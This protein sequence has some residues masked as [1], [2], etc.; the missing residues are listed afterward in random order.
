MG[1]NSYIPIKFDYVFF[2]SC[3]FQFTGNMAPKQTCT[4]FFLMEKMYVFALIVFSFLHTFLLNDSCAIA[5]KGD[6]MFLC[7]SRVMIFFSFPK[8]S[9]F[10]NREI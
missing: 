8:F 5:T 2:F 6:H 9:F 3:Y 4:N 1:E 7:V 10:F